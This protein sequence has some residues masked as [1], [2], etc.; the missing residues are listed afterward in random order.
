MKPL[1]PSEGSLF[2]QAKIKDLTP[3]EILQRERAA[4]AEK[5]ATIEE[6]EKNFVTGHHS[7]V[8]GVESLVKENRDI[9]NAD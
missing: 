9:A 3:Q 5:A 8:T 7:L 4:A 1:R 6:L 2:L